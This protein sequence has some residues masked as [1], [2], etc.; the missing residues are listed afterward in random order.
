M[1]ALQFL[2]DKDVKKDFIVTFNADTTSL[3]VLFDPR[4]TAHSILLDK[5]P[6]L[7]P[8]NIIVTGWC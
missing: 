6:H 5:N 7:L 1:R 3:T 4:D 2:A 8:Y